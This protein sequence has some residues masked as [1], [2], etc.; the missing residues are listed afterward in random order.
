MSNFD[1][2]ASVVIINE[3]IDT[4]RGIAHDLLPPVLE[5][6]GLKQALIELVEKYERTDQL[7]IYLQVVNLPSLSTK[8]MIELNIFRIIQELVNNSIKHGKAKEI[9]IILEK[10]DQ[11]IK[12]YY[13]DKGKGFNTDDKFTNGKGLGMKNIESRIQILKGKWCYES[14]PNQGFKATFSQIP[15]YEQN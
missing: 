5:E 1:I 11:E 6:F 2:V 4:T 15:L 8:S 7:Q 14:S 13:K 10:Q 12:L 3:A 9:S